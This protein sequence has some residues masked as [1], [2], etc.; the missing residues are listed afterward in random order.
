MN[1][2]SRA[3]RW[4]LTTGGDVWSRSPAVLSGMVTGPGRQTDSQV[5]P[6]GWRRRGLDGSDLSAATP[7]GNF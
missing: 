2:S 4:L 1:V 6:R 3:H 5:G 7:P